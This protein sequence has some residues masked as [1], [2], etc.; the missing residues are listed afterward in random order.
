MWLDK[1][2]VS[3]LLSIT[4]LLS[5]YVLIAPP[6]PDPCELI[7]HVLVGDWLMVTFVPLSNVPISCLV[8][9]AFCKLFILDTTRLPVGNETGPFTTKSNIL[10][11]DESI[12][13]LCK[14]GIFEKGPAPTF[15][16]SKA[17][18]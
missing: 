4:R 17:A 11:D 3:A 14:V 9:K 10:Q 6:P 2:I 13:V 7:V 15:I 18:K 1:F 16:K 12:V 5:V 8:F